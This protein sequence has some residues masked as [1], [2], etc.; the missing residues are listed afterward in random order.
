MTAA[1]SAEFLHKLRRRCVTRR[2]R[3][4]RDRV[5]HPA[6]ESPGSFRRPTARDAPRVR[7]A[8]RACRECATRA[9]TRRALA[10][11]R[12][13]GHPSLDPSAKHPRVRERGARRSSC[14]VAHVAARRRRRRRR[15]WTPRARRHRSHRAFTDDTARRRR[16]RRRHH[17]WHHHHHHHRC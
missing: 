4:S 3:Q 1:S 5:R 7:G 13:G 15:L 11:E 9:E 17:R 14:A 8:R 6:R 12:A 16:R 2:S 10:R